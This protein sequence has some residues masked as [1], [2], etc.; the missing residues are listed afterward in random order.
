MFSIFLLQAT[1]HPFYLHV[2]VEIYNSLE[3]YTKAEYEF[4]FNYSIFSKNNSIIPKSQ[5]FLFLWKISKFCGMN[6]L[7]HLVELHPFSTP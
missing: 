5:I 2:G 7:N 4:D 1:K 6:V 3:N